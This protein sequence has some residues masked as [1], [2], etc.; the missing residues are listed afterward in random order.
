MA[1]MD[2]GWLNKGGLQGAIDNGMKINDA[3]S[4]AIQIVPGTQLQAAPP[5]APSQGTLGVKDSTEGA[6]TKFGQKE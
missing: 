1:E 6:L 3:P 2:L 5:E 4:G